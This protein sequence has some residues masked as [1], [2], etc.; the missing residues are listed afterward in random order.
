MAVR[1]HMHHL[2]LGLAVAAVT[3]APLPSAG[4][5]PPMPAPSVRSPGV[6]IAPVGANPLAPKLVYPASGVAF[7]QGS[8]SFK[9]V[10][11]QWEWTKD[12]SNIQGWYICFYK[13]GT[14]CGPIGDWHYGKAEWVRKAS[15]A[16]P[17]V[18]DVQKWRWKV[19]RK[20]KGGGAVTWSEER[21]LTMYSRA[22]LV[23]LESPEAGVSVT[24]PGTMT[25]TWKATPATE[26]YQLCSVRG[27]FS[28]W[29]SCPDT[30]GAS[31]GANW[32]IQT[33]DIKTS[34]TIANVAEVINLMGTD[35][36]SIRKW[37]V[38]ACR[39]VQE[40]SDVDDGQPPVTAMHCRQSNMRSMTVKR[41]P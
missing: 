36:S 30:P 39:M 32:L 14:S 5:T 35:T 15:M 11:I 2:W 18:A 27:G 3:L 10:Y 16:I 23:E 24:V 12:E 31:S 22:S 41:A 4:E 19:G 6:P 7:E 25:F 21:V 29:G 17:I 34:K 37:G 28:G 20:P 8:H 26:F 33:N 38:K 1:L 40:Q 9:H 13:D